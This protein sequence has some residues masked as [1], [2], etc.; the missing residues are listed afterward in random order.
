M[1]LVCVQVM[2][3]VSWVGPIITAGI[4]AATISSALTSLV[5]A[6]K[7]F[8]V[9]SIFLSWVVSDLCWTLL[10]NNDYVHAIG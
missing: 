3:M 8:Q 7:V 9:R 1:L 6:P 4:F 10:H 5:S 2:E